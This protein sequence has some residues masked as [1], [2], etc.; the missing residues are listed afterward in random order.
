MHD[1][2]PKVI[3]C[4]GAGVRAGLVTSAR[5]DWPEGLPTL[6]GLMVAS[7]VRWKGGRGMEAVE[8]GEERGMP[9]GRG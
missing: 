4:Y 7:R 8:R 5:P 9:Q 2:T 3:D 1:S 6:C